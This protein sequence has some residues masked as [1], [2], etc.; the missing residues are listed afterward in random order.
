[1]KAHSPYRGAGRSKYARLATAAALMLALA[2]FAHSAPAAQWVASGRYQ[3]FSE[4]V[5]GS[6]G[7]SGC[8]ANQTPTASGDCPADAA[9]GWLPNYNAAVAAA[10]AVE[11]TGVCRLGY[12][13]PS[14]CR[15]AGYAIQ[16]VGVSA[17]ETF[18]PGADLPLPCTSGAHAVTYV[19]FRRVTDSPDGTPDDR[20]IESD[21]MADEFTCQ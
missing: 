1:M 2:G 20:G 3:Y 10:D 17:G 12:Q 21:Y 16:G 5:L 14:S 7:S 6:N 8:Q 13:Y 19:I 18:Q 15:F 11:A 9:T 4:G